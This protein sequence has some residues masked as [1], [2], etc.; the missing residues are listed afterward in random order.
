M[1]GRPPELRR[2]LLALVGLVVVVDAAFLA[3]YF[4]ADLPGASGQT[5][6]AF[7]AG[8]TVAT[9]L[10]VLRGLGRI[11]AARVGGRRR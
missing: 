5:R 7:T 6:L 9:L 4:A 2:E 10:V 1:A 3:V 8:W 11:R